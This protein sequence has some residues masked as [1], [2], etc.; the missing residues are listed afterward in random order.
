MNIRKRC[1]ALIVSL[2]S[3]FPI[4]TSAQDT[5]FYPMLEQSAYYGEKIATFVYEPGMKVHINAPSEDKFNRTKPTKIVFFALPNGNTTL[6]TIGKRSSEGDDYRFD[7][8]HIGAQTRYLRNKTDDYNLVTIYMEADGRSWANWRRGGRGSG[9]MLP[10]RTALIKEFVEYILELFGNYNPHIE[11]NSHSGG[12]NFIFGFIDSV[13]EIPDYVTKIT[14][15]DSDYAW[16]DEQ[17]GDKLVNWL[18]KSPDHGLFVACYDDANALLDGKHFVSKKGGTWYRSNM[19]RKYVKRH[20]TGLNWT[21]HEDD[22]I[23]HYTA[24][25]RKVQFFFRKNPEQKIYHTILVEKNGFIHSVLMGTEN[26][27]NGYKFF[28]SRVYNEY[29]QDSVE[30]PHVLTFP[31]FKGEK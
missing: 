5:D 29:R 10:E 2:S 28:G 17:Y 3:F 16:T 1:I 15:I 27:E 31:P 26:D 12:G 20:A 19:M 14:F 25:D 4:S 11:L 6:H 18:N 7:I 13:D 22:S 8:Q 9:E 23:R 24:R 30:T 21:K